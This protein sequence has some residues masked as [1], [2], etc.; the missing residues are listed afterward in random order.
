MKFDRP[1]P[2]NDRNRVGR[3]DKV[4]GR[5]VSEIGETK[6]FRYIGR[7]R[8]RLQKF[9]EW[10]KLFSVKWLAVSSADNCSTGTN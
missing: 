9:E 6:V 1:T 4:D 5:V 10:R 2:K 7:I 3:N 8:G